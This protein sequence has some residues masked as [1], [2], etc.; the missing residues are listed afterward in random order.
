MSEIKFS[1]NG[2]LF[3]FSDWQLIDVELQ[4]RE[5][6]WH[7]DEIFKEQYHRIDKSKI[8][9]LKLFYEWSMIHAG[10]EPFLF[11][12]IEASP[13]LFWEEYVILIDVYEELYRTT[14]S[15]CQTLDEA[16]DKVDYFLIN[17]DKYHRRYKNLQ[18]MK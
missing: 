14:V 8:A 2:S 13:P 11:M 1:I 12:E 9:N 17:F 7:Q 4:Y 3:D 18:V 10:V 5:T 6:E 16:K 15:Q